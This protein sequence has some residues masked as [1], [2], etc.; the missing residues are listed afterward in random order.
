MYIVEMDKEMDKWWVNIYNTETYNNE[1]CVLSSVEPE[2]VLFDSSNY[3][4]D[5]YTFIYVQYAQ[6]W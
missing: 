3:N 1:W 2:W 5:F 6:K 4:K